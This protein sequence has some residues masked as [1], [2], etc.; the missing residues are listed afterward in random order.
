M[1]MPVVSAVQVRVN[2]SHDARLL[3]ITD[4]QTWQEKRNTPGEIIVLDGIDAQ[5]IN[6][7]ETMAMNK[8]YWDTQGWDVTNLYDS[9]YRAIITWNTSDIPNDAIITDATVTVMGHTKANLLGT[10]DS[11]IVDANPFNPMAFVGADY[12]RTEFTRLAPDIT[13]YNF[14]DNNWNSF[15]L[16]SIGID[17]INKAGYTSFMFAHSADVDNASALSTWESYVSSGYEIR[18]M[19]YLNGT[20]TPYMTINYDLPVP[21]PVASFTT[22]TTSG[23]APL[24][25]QFNDTS[26][27]SPKSWNWSFGDG[28]WSNTTV[29]GARNVT[30]TY[31]N[32]GSCIV[33]LTVANTGGANTTYPGTTITVNSPVIIGN[34]TIGVY[35]NGNFFLKN[36]N[37]AGNADLVFEYGISSDTPLVGDWNGDGTDTVGIYRDGNFFLKNSNSA[38]NADLVFGYGISSDTP[39][40][41]DWNGD[42]TDTVGIYRN[43]N[44]FLK[45]S[46]S[47][48]NADLVFGYGI[49]SDTPLV[50]D[51]NGL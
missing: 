36:S 43:G 12:S 19:N 41:G 22:N 31:N 40:V 33:Q 17:H 45:N 39:L 49:S 10:Y 34:D 46:N 8:T 15:T 47:A 32:P 37:S 44:F 2:A 18:G 28:I 20:Y 4:N 26:S 27:N 21:A 50:G 48:G 16:N 30:H 24:T 14:K 3:A 9:H 1:L 5:T 7:G 11:C 35:R 25:V 6:I 51:W 29:S 13:Y 42:G 38:G 23:T